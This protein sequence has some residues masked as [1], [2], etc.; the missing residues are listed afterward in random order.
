MK[1]T[2]IGTLLL[3][4]MLSGAP[5][6]AATTCLCIGMGNSKSC[7]NGAIGGSF[8]KV[9]TPNTTSLIYYLKTAAFVAELNAAGKAFNPN[10]GWFCWNGQL[11]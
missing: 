8:L 1:K 3:G 10:T 2:I 5:A 4:L 7:G 6:G 9:A 11:R